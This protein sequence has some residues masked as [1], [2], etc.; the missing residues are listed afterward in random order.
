MMATFSSRRSHLLFLWSLVSTSFLFAS[1]CFSPITPQHSAPSSSSTSYLPSPPPLVYVSALHQDGSTRAHSHPSSFSE[2]HAS[3]LGQ[4]TN[5]T[6]A[7]SQGGGGKDTSIQE[8]DEIAFRAAEA[9][10]AAYVRAHAKGVEP[11]SLAAVI[12]EQYNPLAPDTD[13]AQDRDGASQTALT[14]VKKGGGSLYADGGECI[15]FAAEEGDNDNCSCPE[16]F[17]LCN[18]EDVLAV[19]ESQKAVERVASRAWVREF[20]LKSDRLPAQTLSSFDA[21]AAAALHTNSTYLRSTTGADVDSPDN[22]SVSGKIT[23]LTAAA[24]GEG[25]T[26]DGSTPLSTTTTTT[27]TTTPKEDI[28]S[29]LAEAEKR[30]KALASGENLMVKK[31]LASDFDQ[32][33]KIQRSQL[34]PALLEH[35]DQLAKLAAGKVAPGWL[36]ALCSNDPQEGFQEYSVYIDYEV[37]IRCANNSTKELPDFQ[38]QYALNTYVDPG[39]MQKLKAKT[40]GWAP[41]HCLVSDFYLCRRAPPGV[42]KVNCTI[43]EWTDWSKCGEDKT[44]LRKRRILRS[45]QHGGNVCVWEGKQPVHSEVTE[46]RPCQEGKEAEKH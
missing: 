16:G 31:D 46:S 28:G 39:R 3:L 36:K 32:I 12:P 41:R 26:P 14:G 30:D 42:T 20:L 1:L 35:G 18:W 19:R 34:P 44:Q 10:A 4:S 2:L 27:T 17:V 13:T 29:N 21:A 33:D 25:G 11:P 40:E 37:E 22:T 38:F 15:I 7:V 5:T 6:A 8:V 23:P 24:S 43:E 45:G 9:A